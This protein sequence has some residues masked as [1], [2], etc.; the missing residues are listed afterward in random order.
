MLSPEAKQRIRLALWV[1]LALVTLR[2]AYIFYQRHQDR[3]GVEKQ[4][5]AR[6]AGYSNPDYYVSPKKLYPYDLKSTKQL[7]QQPEWVKEGY[8]YT[9]YSYE[10]ATKRVQ[11]GH[12]AGL[13]G[14]IEKVVITD[15]VMATA[16]GTTQ[17]HQ[18]MAIFQKDDK[19]YAV[20]VGYEAGGEY[21][22][23]SDEMFYIEDP[24]ALYKHWSPDVWQ[25][26]EQHQVKPGMNET[27]AVFAVGMGRPDAGS[28]SDE[29]TV[30]YPN[31]GKPL[32]VVYHDG[33]AADVKPD[34][35]GS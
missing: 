24:H 28:S 11:F 4:A 1:L 35:Q 5:R 30:H 16:P 26:V 3:V 13:L 29:K 32:V 21:K 9:Y 31:G 33:K 10:P 25:A 22:I 34:S 27:Q 7:T 18:V 20:P 12:E 15:V 19:S 17:K 6:N 8:R 2:A 23:Y 14:P